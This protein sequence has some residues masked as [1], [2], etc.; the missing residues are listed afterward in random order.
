M[1]PVLQRLFLLAA[2]GVLLALGLVAAAFG[3]VAVTVYAGAVAALVGFGL[4]RARAVV[5]AR[6]RAGRPAGRTCRC[7][8]ST[9]HDPVQVI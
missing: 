2:A 1:T 4:R 6:Q 9:V 7:C 3:L 8:T 5:G